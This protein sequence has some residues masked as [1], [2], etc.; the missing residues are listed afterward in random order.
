MK[1]Q[2]A[3]TEIKAP[4][5]KAQKP[6]NYVQ[7]VKNALGQ[8]FWSIGVPGAEDIT[9]DDI[10]KY[11]VVFVFD[12]LITDCCAADWILTKHIAKLSYYWAD[13]KDLV[14]DLTFGQPGSGLTSDIDSSIGF[15][16]SFGNRKVTLTL[17]LELGDSYKE[18]HCASDTVLQK[19]IYAHCQNLY[20]YLN[21]KKV[22]KSLD[23]M[24]NTY[25]VKSES[26]KNLIAFATLP[27]CPSM[28][29]K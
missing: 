5:T 15:R 12:I 2:V 26:L 29:T 1:T 24:L 27:T 14:V 8:N 9:V 7:R 17:L 25:T 11:A 21:D 4:A 13:A 18:V 6:S 20:E 28:D 19:L 16:F 10:G 3:A 23:T 22:R